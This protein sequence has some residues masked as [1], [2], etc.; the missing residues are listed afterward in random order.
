MTPSF[1]FFLLTLLFLYAAVGMILSA[2]ARTGIGVTLF[3]LLLYG[4]YRYRDPLARLR[5]RLD[6]LARLNAWRKE[7]TYRRMRLVWAKVLERHA[8]DLRCPEC[9]VE[10]TVFTV[11]IAG[12][13][14]VCGRNLLP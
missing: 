4:L 7:R 8:A 12:R 9:S 13:C 6:P 1:P 14:L 2:F 3:L 11:S 5:R 10:L